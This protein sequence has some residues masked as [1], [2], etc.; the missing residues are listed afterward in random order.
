MSTTLPPR[1][2]DWRAGGGIERVDGHQIFVRRDEGNGPLLLFLHGFPSSSYD[3]REVLPLLGARATLALDFLGF[4][5]SDKPR[6]SVYSLFGQADIV[7]RLVGD[8]ARPVIVVAHDMGTSVATELLA[9]DL[10]GR[11][12]FEIR[13]ALLFNGGM[14]VE[15]ASLT[16]AQQALRSPLGPLVARLSNR[17]LFVSQFGRLFSEA[18][19]LSAAEAQD[20]RALW[21]HADGDRLAHRL[22][23]YIDERQAHA[24]RWHGAIRD[25][26]G[27]LQFAWGMRD[28]VATPNV[29]AGLREL[30]PAAP[31]RELADLGHYPQIEAPARITAE[32]EEIVSAAA[33]AGPTALGGDR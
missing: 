1:L 20:Q 32:I 28:P 10:E 5:L 17:P 16:W 19:P 9:R 3:W 2:L 29:L 21:R 30:R 25:W 31:V 18:H 13:G 33:Q 24:P 14:I 7:E 15:R 11:L 12:S 26:P 22:I 6:D 4:G 8:E 23:K 27:Q